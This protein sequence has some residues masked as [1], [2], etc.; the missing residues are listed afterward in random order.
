MPN[1]NIAQFLL[2]WH[3]HWVYDS[4]A[5]K[6][7]D[8][9]TAERRSLSISNVSERKKKRHVALKKFS[10]YFSQKDLGE[11]VVDKRLEHKIVKENWRE[12]I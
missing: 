1:D 4:Q 8:F 6:E 9:E 12:R 2:Q 11:E 7:S 3:D 5:W 10:K